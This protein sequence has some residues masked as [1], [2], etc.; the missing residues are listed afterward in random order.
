MSRGVS[1]SVQQE[2]SGRLLRNP[3]SDRKED[4]LEFEMEIV[5]RERAAGPV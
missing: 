1:G 5:S 4:T 2:I 3:P